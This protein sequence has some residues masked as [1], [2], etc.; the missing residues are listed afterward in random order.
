MRAGFLGSEQAAATG[1][2]PLSHTSGK[3]QNFTLYQNRVI[4]LYPQRTL[5]AKRM[6]FITP[7][8]LLTGPKSVL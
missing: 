4:L 1:C 2:H 7:L 8:N 5:S 6:T 3:A